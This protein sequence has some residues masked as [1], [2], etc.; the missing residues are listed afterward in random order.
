M[1]RKWKMMLC[2][3]IFEVEADS[4]EDALAEASATFMAQTMPDDFIVLHEVPTSELAE[5]GKSGEQK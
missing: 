1:K 3:Q 2:E 4:E 5:Q